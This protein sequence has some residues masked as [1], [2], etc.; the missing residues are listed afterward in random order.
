MV[1]TSSMAS[2]RTV[3][4]SLLDAMDNA[5]E[6]VSARLSGM[7]ESEYAWQPVAECWTVR[8]HGGHWLA[9]W[10]DPDPDPAPVTTIAWRTWHVAVDSLDSYSERLFGVRGT[11]L[12]GTNWVGTWREAEPL[13]AAAFDVYRRGVAGWT[14]KTLLAPLG[15]QWGPFAHHTHLDLALHA[16]RELI[17]HL[18]EIA[19]LRDLYRAMLDQR[20]SDFLP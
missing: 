11:G 9:D 1:F 13:M 20:G 17:H 19:L 7:S 16:I 14:D 5:W 6:P 15:A 12:T 10:A 18:A 8:T 2:S 3:H 4:R